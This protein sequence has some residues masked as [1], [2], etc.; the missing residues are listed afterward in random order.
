MKDQ[1]EF[2]YLQGGMDFSK[3]NWFH[4]LLMKARK[5]MTLRKNKDEWTSNDQGF[6]ESY[7]KSVDFTSQEKVKP[8]VTLKACAKTKAVP[9]KKTSTTNNI[10]ATKIK[11]N[12]IVSV[13]P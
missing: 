10:G 9:A 12:S 13:I 4:R 2:F 3:M 6:I 8:I 11:V 5:W 7:G 1:I